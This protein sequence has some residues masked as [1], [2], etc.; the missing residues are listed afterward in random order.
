MNTQTTKPRPLRHMLA[1]VALADQLPMPRLIS[2]QGQG[3]GKAGT[4]IMGMSFDSV[5]AGQAWSRYLGGKTD[6]HTHTDSG[7]TYLR[8]GS[9]AW[10]GWHVQLQASDDAAPDTQLDEGITAQLVA[11]AAGAR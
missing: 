11:I 1:L 2:F 4:S 5:A 7:R 6:T 8:E 3:A 10:H 9:I